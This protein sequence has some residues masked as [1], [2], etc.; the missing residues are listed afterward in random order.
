MSDFLQVEAIATPHQSGPGQMRS[1]TDTTLGLSYFPVFDS[2]PAPFENGGIIRFGDWERIEA[3]YRR[4]VNHPL[5]ILSGMLHLNSYTFVENDALAVH[6]ER[7]QA[8]VGEPVGWGG[9]YAEDYIRDH[10]LDAIIAGK[11]AGNGVR[12][13]LKNPT[14]RPL[15]RAI[16]LSSPG[17]DIYGHWLIDMLPRLAMLS[18]LFVE[19]VPILLNAVPPWAGY[20]LEALDIDPR[21]IKAHPARSF[22]VETAMIPT[23]AKAGHVLARRLLNEAWDRVVDYHSRHPAKVKTARKLFLSR[24]RWELRQREFSDRAKVDELMAQRGYAVI[25]PEDLST[26]QQIALMQSA[27]VVIGEDGSALHNVAFCR[28]GAVLGVLS[29]PERDSFYHYSICQIRGHKVGYCSVPEAQDG[30]APER[31]LNAFL[32]AVEVDADL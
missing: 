9:D 18:H 31:R 24:S 17:H 32:D 27:R 5:L 25:H 30:K 2:R 3:Q 29:T 23:M 26:S 10:G 7:R 8:L 22:S 1:F 21:R 19:D 16:I 4:M 12:A 13:F 28:R 20:F 15:P 14:G 11:T 6:P